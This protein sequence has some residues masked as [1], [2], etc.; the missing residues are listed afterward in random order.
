MENSKNNNEDLN[1]LK[2][3]GISTANMPKEGTKEFNQLIGEYALRNKDTLKTK[4]NV[5]INDNMSSPSMFVNME[6][7]NQTGEFVLKDIFT[8]AR[9]AFPSS[10]ISDPKLKLLIVNTVNSYKKKNIIG[11]RGNIYIKK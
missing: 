9:E 2:A 7:L 5:K 8:K 3:G 6:I 4:S 10:K 11:Q 1:K